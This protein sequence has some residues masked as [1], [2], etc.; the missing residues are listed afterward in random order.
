[1]VNWN[2]GWFCFWRPFPATRILRFRDFW[3]VKRH[4]MVDQHGYMS[5]IMKL[6]YDLGYTNI[7]SDHRSHLAPSP[8]PS[9]SPNS[10]ILFDVAA[11]KVLGSFA[12]TA[13]Y[14]GLIFD[15]TWCKCKACPVI[16]SRK[17]RI[18]NNI[19]LKQIHTVSWLFWFSFRFCVFA[20]QI[21]ER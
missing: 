6:P 12:G 11:S 9:G 21:P 20:S 2:L 7:S 4:Q 8:C 17:I 19:G 10:S 13:K 1:M 3:W 18:I 16:L 15:G 14:D 5:S